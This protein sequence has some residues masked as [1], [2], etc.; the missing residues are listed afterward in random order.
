MKYSI[1]LMPAFFLL[2]GLANCAT[3]SVDILWY[4]PSDASLKVPTVTLENEQDTAVTIRGLELAV[5]SNTTKETIK[6]KQLVT[7]P[8]NRYGGYRGWIPV[9]MEGTSQAF[10]DKG[11]YNVTMIEAYG[12]LYAEG[13]DPNSKI[14]R[15]KELIDRWQID[16]EAMR[17][18][19]RQN[20]TIFRGSLYEKDYDYAE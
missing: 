3:Q 5:Y 13:E 14:Y 19:T 18:L 10:R 2:L 12:Y 20:D 8:A 4:E 6:I 7:I 15:P 17:N 16:P 11:R 1:L 9:Q